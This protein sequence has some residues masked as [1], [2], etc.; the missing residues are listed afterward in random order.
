MSLCRKKQEC[1]FNKTKNHCE[2]C[3]IPLIAMKLRWGTVSFL[4]VCEAGGRLRSNRRSLHFGRDDTAFS[5]RLAG[6]GV[7]RCVVDLVGT[8]EGGLDVGHDV[9]APDAIEEAATLQKL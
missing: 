9:L 2:V 4:W 5:E 3:T 6:F 8:I 7:V 1:K